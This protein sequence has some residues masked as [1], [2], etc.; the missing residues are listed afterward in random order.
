[1]PNPCNTATTI[2]F[3]V[4]VPGASLR[5]E[6]LD[7]AGRQL[8]DWHLVATG[9]VQTLRWDGTDADGTA[10]ASGVYL[11]RPVAPP[12]VAARRVVVVR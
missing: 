4:P 6:I 1:V 12:G 5:V 3:T 11:C 9:G 7:L 2:P 8:R 10:V